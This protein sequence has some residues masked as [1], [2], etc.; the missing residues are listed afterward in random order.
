MCPERE[1]DAHRLYVIGKRHY[2]K[3]T[4][5]YSTA[6][7]PKTIADL[8]RRTTER[9]PAFKIYPRDKLAEDTGWDRLDIRNALHG[10]WFLIEEGP[11]GET[12]VLEQ[13]QLEEDKKG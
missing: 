4:Y 9:D 12:V 10:T 2:E 5:F 8:V 11:G 1:T 3:T 7:L 13:G 6:E